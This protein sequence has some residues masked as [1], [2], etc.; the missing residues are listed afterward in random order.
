[1]RRWLSIAGTAG[2]GI[3]VLASA[4]DAR[5]QG[6]L[7][8]YSEQSSQLIAKLE[9][10]VDGAT[11]LGVG[12]AMVYPAL[13]AAAA[14]ISPVAKRATT[15]GWYRFWRD[16]G[17]PVGALLAGVVSATF[18]LVWAIYLAGLLTFASGMAAALLI[19]A[20][21]FPRPIAARAR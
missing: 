21:R 2:L 9:C 1:M 7:D 17:Y 20:Q 14:D 11:L 19:A 4:P 16:L 5:A 3:S 12:T 18:G 15:L 10:R 6:V 13:L 8:S